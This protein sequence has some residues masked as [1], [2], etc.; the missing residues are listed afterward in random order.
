[1]GEA[2]NR[3]NVSFQTHHLN[4]R[5][6]SQ[7]VFIGHVLTNH[8][9]RMPMILPHW[10]ENNNTHWIKDLPRSL[11]HL[12]G[13]LG[14]ALKVVGVCRNEPFRQ[15]LRKL[16]YKTCILLLTKLTHFRYTWLEIMGY[17]ITDFHKAGSK[18]AFLSRVRWITS[19]S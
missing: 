2:S 7:V 12:V 14:R 15:T 9:K 16:V 6:Y 5:L 18:F 13:C 11:A 4:F 8:I 19:L 10:S 17:D 1:M 3:K